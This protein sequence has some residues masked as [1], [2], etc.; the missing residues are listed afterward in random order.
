MTDSEEN[1]VFAN[2]PK[3]NSFLIQL[4]RS[5]SITKKDLRIY[6][7]KGPVVIQ[8]ILFPIVLFI[9]FSIGRDIEQL[10]IV[11]GLTSM[12]IFLTA[13]S[14]GPIVFPWETRQKT[15]ERLIACPITIRTILLGNIW[16][17]L[18]FGGVFSLVPLILG[19]SIFG[20][21]GSMKPWII[22]PGIIIA[23]LTF[24]S[25]SLILSVPPTDM[26]ANT[27]MLTVMIKFPLVF[28]SPLFMP[29]IIPS[30]VVVSPLTYFVDIIN[31][32][33]NGTSAFGT[34]G[35]LLDFGVLIGFGLVFL[36]LAFFLHG[37]TIDKRF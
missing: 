8:G 17:S 33:F 19:T 20:M 2:R 15:L 18:I 3:A 32:G 22:I 1:D 35:L 27:M 25:F 11:S 16:S 36:L 6:Y 12:V 9:A 29:I 10:Y 4:K 21:W 5:F 13:T 34:Y 23:A 37:K 7:N 30:Y 31:A 26:P 14:I 28:I 24:S